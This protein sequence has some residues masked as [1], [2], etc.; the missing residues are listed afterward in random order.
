MDSG[1]SDLSPEPARGAVTDRRYYPPW[2]FGILYGGTF[3]GFAAVSL[4]Q[5]LPDRGVSLERVAEIVTLILTASYVSFLVTPLVDCGLPRRVWAGLLAVTAAVCL[6]FSVPLLNAAG[7]NGGHGA[8][9]ATLMLVLFVG[10]LC[11]QVYTSAIGGMVPNLVAPQ[12]HGAVSAWMNISYL[13]LTGAGGALSVWEIRHLPLP[14]ATLLVPVPIL[15]GAI[16]LLFLP[17][18]SRRPRPVGEAMRQL[19]HDL[20]ATAKKPTYL[21]A[22]LVFVVPSATFAL[23]N[24]FGG[25]GSDFHAGPELTNLSVG[26]LFTIAC[27][28]GA[29]IGGPLSSRFDRRLLFIAPAML[30]ALGSLV[31]I[32]GPHTPWMFAGGLFFYNLM[33]GINYTATSALVFQIVGRDNPL[34]ATQ[35]SV[36][37]AACNLAIAG[38]VFMDGRGSGHGGA[39]GALAVDAAL[40]LVLGTLVLALVWKFGGG[41]PKPPASEDELERVAKAA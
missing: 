35:Y 38:S 7:R 33:A 12:R 3:N 24:L 29:A 10:Y 17:K 1:T 39:N 28:I 23:Q 5:L 4:S 34:S 2:M 16:P 13:A 8:G 25:M 14:V 37:I 15:L 19:F 31:M 36:C 11:N 40:S 26:L 21:F 30:A 32:F 22:L 41:F 6:G 18:E 20:S 9:A 27:A